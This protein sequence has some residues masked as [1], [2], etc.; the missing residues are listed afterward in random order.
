MQEVLPYRTGGMVA[1]ETRV[2]C[3][4]VRGPIYQAV[5]KFDNGYGA[6]VIYGAGTYGVE[7]AVALF[8]ENGDWDITYDTPI[9]DDVIAYI[10][11][12]AELISLLCEVRDLPPA[13][14]QVKGR[15]RVTRNAIN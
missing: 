13:R 15:Y 12:E 4:N 14:A 2:M 5:F 9:T 11:D 3:T 8:D 10:P 7:M 6:S 1:V